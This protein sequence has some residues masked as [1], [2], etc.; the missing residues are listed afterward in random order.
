[1]ITQSLGSL[2]ARLKEPF[3]F[4]F[5]AEW[6]EPF[7]VFDDQDSG[8]FCLGVEKE[9][10]RRFLK[11][12]GPR[13]VRGTV[14]PRDAVAR[15]KSTVPVYGDLR[16]PVLV[17]LEVHGPI[18]GGYLLAFDWFDGACMGRMYGQIERFLALPV[19]K[20]L[21]L[22]SAILD[23]HRH[24]NDSGYVAVDFYDGS[25]LYNFA[26]RETRICDIE[27]YSR[28]PYINEMG[29]LWGSGRFMSPEE[30]TFGAAIDE[31][32]NVFCM[33]AM[34][35]FLF[36]NA[37]EDRSAGVWNA[38][39]PLYDVAAKATLPNRAGRFPDIAA[40]MAAW[41]NAIAACAPVLY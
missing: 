40:Y 31:R 34:A 28:M 37:G 24:V 27:F 29:R 10:C 11:I 8:N 5:L 23:F 25:V 12:V 21:E 13:T 32:S 18:P 39:A 15:L 41:N 19:G 17:N 16:H 36:G 3:D 20:K 35:F 38:P 2:T 26:T 14:S 30:F 22:Y 6:G 33:G 4:S 7:A 1:M 9:G